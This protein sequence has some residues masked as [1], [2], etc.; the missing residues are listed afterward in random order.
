[1]VAF[2]DRLWNRIFHN[3]KLVRIIASHRKYNYCFFDGKNQLRYL[4]NNVY[5][6]T[7]K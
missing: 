4:G 3:K 1:M 7:D 2:F 5:K 6:I